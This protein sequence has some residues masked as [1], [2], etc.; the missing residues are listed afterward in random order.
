[1]RFI[2]LIL[3]FVR[4]GTATCPKSGMRHVPRNGRNTH[5]GTIRGSGLR[6][7]ILNRGPVRDTQDSNE[8]GLNRLVWG[9][10]R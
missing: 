5:S 7:T 6:G 9:Q 10:L 1:M 4:S 2:E 8:G 3:L